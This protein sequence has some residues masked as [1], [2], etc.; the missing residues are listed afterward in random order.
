MN[1]ADTQN[2]VQT[3]G[4]VKPRL[5]V[6]DNLQA[7]TANAVF[8]EQETDEIVRALKSLAAELDEP[9]ILMSRPDHS[10]IRHD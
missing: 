3:H 9:I 5:I 7:V 10:N 2:Y 4:S 1:A 8:P 6:I